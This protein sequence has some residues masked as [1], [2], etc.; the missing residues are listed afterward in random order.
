MS[1]VKYKRGMFKRAFSYKHPRP[2][3]SK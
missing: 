2:K 3:K 1:S